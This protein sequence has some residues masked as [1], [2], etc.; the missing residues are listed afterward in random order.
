MINESLNYAIAV[1]VGALA[2]KVATLPTLPTAQTEMGISIFGGD[3]DVTVYDI[4]LQKLTSVVQSAKPTLI[5]RVGVN[6]RINAAEEKAFLKK[7]GIP[8]KHYKEMPQKAQELNN[9]Y[10][11]LWH[12]TT[13]VNP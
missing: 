6:G 10:K 8:F 3:N 9:K 4:S 7:A 11:V 2:H 5:V 13:T 1:A 12:L